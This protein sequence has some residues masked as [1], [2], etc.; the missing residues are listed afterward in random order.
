MTQTQQVLD[1]TFY[2]GKNQKTE[3]SQWK[4]DGMSGRTSVVYVPDQH[5]MLQ[6][7]ADCKRFLCYRGRTVFESPSKTF[8][9]VAVDLFETITAQV[10]QVAQTVELEADPGEVEYDFELEFKRGKNPTTGAM[11]WKRWSS[12]AATRSP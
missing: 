6:P 7:S 2:L 12:S 10:S 8:M 3:A 1:L 4:S 9:I 5:S 11:Q